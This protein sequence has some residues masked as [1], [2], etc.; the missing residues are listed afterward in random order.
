[1]GLGALIAFEG[2]SVEVTDATD[3]RKAMLHLD[4]YGGGMAIFNKSGENVLQTSVNNAGD[5]VI[6]TWDQF[7]DV[8]GGFPEDKKVK[9]IKRLR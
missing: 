1:M 8:T 7:G 5:G 6:F 2:G 3:R 9:I 4:D